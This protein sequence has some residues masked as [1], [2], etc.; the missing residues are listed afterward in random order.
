MPNEEVM[1]CPDAIKFDIEKECI[2]VHFA[3]CKMNT[4]ISG[5]KVEKEN[6][7]TEFSISFEPEQFISTIAMMARVAYKYQAD[8]KTNLGLSLNENKVVN[9]DEK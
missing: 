6:I 7:E 2:A 4:T 1:N 5:K 3:K 8:F 9:K